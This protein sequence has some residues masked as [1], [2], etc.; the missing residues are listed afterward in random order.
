MDKGTSVSSVRETCKWASQ[1]WLSIFPSWVRQCLC[2]AFNDHSFLSILW[3]NEGHFVILNRR[4]LFTSGNLLFF[5]WIFSGSLWYFPVLWLGILVTYVH[6]NFTK[7]NYRVFLD[8]CM[9]QLEAQTKSHTLG[10]EF[11]LQLSFRDFFTKL[12]NLPMLCL[13]ANLKKN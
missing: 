6:L 2:F 7:F 9:S 3:F 1:Q 12:R 13:I 8:T 5:F 11:Y 10:G 4:P